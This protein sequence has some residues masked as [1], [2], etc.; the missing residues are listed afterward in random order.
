MRGNLKFLHYKF[1]DKP[2]FRIICGAKNVLSFYYDSNYLANI[3]YILCGI[4]I[5]ASTSIFLLVYPSLSTYYT[6]FYWY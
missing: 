2:L 3:Y 6:D 5:L 1:S 4:R